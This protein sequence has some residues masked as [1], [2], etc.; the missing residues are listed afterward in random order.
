MTGTLITV[1]EDAE[2]GL[3]YG[4]YLM[5]Y[6]NKLWIATFDIDHAMLIQVQEV[7]MTK[8]KVPEPVGKALREWLL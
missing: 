4:T 1:H 2:T 5:R 7:A 8:E 6:R 3:N